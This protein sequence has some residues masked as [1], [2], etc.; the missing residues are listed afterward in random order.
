M[1]NLKSGIILTAIASV[2]FAQS[3]DIGS[4]A[5]G[6]FVSRGSSLTVEVDR[7]ES[8]TGSSEVGIIIGLR[9]CNPDCSPTDIDDDL[10]LV[11]YGGP[12]NPQFSNVT[13]HKPPHQN[14]T[15]TVPASFDG[16]AVLSVFHVAVVAAANA[17]VEL[18]N[19][20][21]NIQ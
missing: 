9:P 11:L 4:P 1:V 3:I 17:L 13:D 6:S 14:F 16:T 8:L 2:A 5:N 18:K 21:L 12:Y 20:T 7:P 19:V 10:G 15:F